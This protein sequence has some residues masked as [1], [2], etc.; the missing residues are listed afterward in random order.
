MDMLAHAGAIEV[1]S[2]RTIAIHRTVKTLC[3]PHE[4]GTTTVGPLR[5]KDRRVCGLVQ[6]CGA[7][8]MA[9]VVE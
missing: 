3:D 6:P 9:G 4:R 8:A 2:K 5:A 7:S 1:C